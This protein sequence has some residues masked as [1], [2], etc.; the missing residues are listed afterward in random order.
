VIKQFIKNVFKIFGLEIRRYQPFLD[1]S[2]QVHQALK[3]IKTDL[4]FDIGA[5]AGQF[6][7]DMRSKGYKG[8]IVS[9][10]PLASAREKLLKKA[11]K[12]KN[13]LIHEQTAI[14]NHN[15]FV[16][17]NISKNSVSSSILPI[18]SSHSE[19]EVDSVYIGKQKTPI[20]T[21]DSVK[22]KYLNENSNCFVKIDTQG[23]EWQVIDGAINTL[24]KSKGV[25][26]ELSII[27]LYEGQH[28]WKDIIERFEAEGFILWSFQKAFSD[29]RDGRTLQMDA[30]FLKKNEINN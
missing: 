23:Y 4:I 29:K 1:N 2:Y 6:A 25:L 11:E 20:T 30:I 19:A 13:W 17:I 9:F 7:S 12:D 5:N 10:E 15:G 26:C 22:D 21:L 28:L 3:K 14:G 16:D 27:P 8:I 24:K 18:L